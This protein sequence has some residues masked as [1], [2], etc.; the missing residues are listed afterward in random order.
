[1]SIPDAP[2]RAPGTLASPQHMDERIQS[3]RLADQTLTS[4]V[5]SQPRVWLGFSLGAQCLLR[6]AGTCCS[7]TEGP[8]AA[9]LVGCLI[10]VP[11]HVMM[12]IGQFRLVYGENDYV[13]YALDDGTTTDVFG[14]L[15]YGNSCALKLVLR[16]SQRRSVEVWGSCGHLLEPSGGKSLETVSRELAK[17]VLECLED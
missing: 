15:Q 13:T 17:L 8:R 7:L 10:E 6:I 16:Q 9:I 12:N 11:V 4:I 2:S 5:A 1:M 14:P 3:L